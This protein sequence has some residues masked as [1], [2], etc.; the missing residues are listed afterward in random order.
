MGE[1]RE[2]PCSLYKCLLHIWL[3][4]RLVCLPLPSLQG[5]RCCIFLG[6]PTTDTTY[7]NVQLKV[8]INQY[9]PT[10]IFS[11][12]RHRNNQQLAAV[13]SEAARKSSHV[14]LHHG[15]PRAGKRRGASASADNSVHDQDHHLV[16]A[17]VRL[18]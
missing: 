2:E 5:F 11:A 17:D 16:W 15:N 14:S 12:S 10:I 9:T 6:Y 1:W 7:K 3:R 4:T 18:Y 13:H 8:H